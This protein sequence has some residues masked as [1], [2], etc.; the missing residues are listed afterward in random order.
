[1]T[2]CL[3]L[4][5]VGHVLPWLYKKPVKSLFFCLWNNEN[6]KKDI[7]IMKI[8]LYSNSV[9]HLVSPLLEL[10]SKHIDSHWMDWFFLYVALYWRDISFKQLFVVVWHQHVVQV[11]GKSYA[12]K[13]DSLMKFMFA[14]YLYF[15]QPIKAAPPGK[16]YVR[17]PCNCLL[18]CRS[19]AIKIACPRANW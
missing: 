10:Y 7:F 11:H 4:P 5:S 1:M 18:I 14:D 9:N 3:T 17:C 12:K 16:Q 19:G 15:W 2:F 6:T 13:M 8:I